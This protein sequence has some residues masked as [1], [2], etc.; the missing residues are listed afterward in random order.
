[1]KSPRRSAALCGSAAAVPGVSCPLASLLLLSLLHFPPAS[2]R[3]LFPHRR[4]SSVVGPAGPHWLLGAPGF[5]G[6]GSE[7]EGWGWGRVRMKRGRQRFDP[8]LEGLSTS[9]NTRRD[10]KMTHWLQWI[11]YWGAVIFIHLITYC[12]TTSANKNSH[13]VL[14]IMFFQLF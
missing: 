7:R 6:R 12:K 13:S 9:R 11:I 2:H 8:G 14:F 10:P 1:M 4:V 3:P 5:A